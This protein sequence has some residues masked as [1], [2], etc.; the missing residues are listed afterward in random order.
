MNDQLLKQTKQYRTRSRQ[1]V[2]KRR[3]LDLNELASVSASDPNTVLKDDNNNID[4][5]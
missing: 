4:N 5:L 1:G 2:G 3:Y